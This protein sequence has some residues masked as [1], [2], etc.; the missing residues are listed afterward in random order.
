MT[1]QHDAAIRRR[2]DGSIDTDFYARRAAL[3]RA[4]AL[5]DEPARW[6]ASLGRAVAALASAA[7]VTRPSGFG[8]TW[9]RRGRRA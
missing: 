6:I 8:L 1:S 5:K 7:Q 2:P 4:T 3:L 9:S